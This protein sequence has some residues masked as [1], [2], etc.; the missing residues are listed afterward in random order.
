MGEGVGQP[1][2]RGDNK[3][4]E[5]RGQIFDKMGNTGGKIQ[6][7]NYAGQFC[8]MGFNSYE[9]FKISHDYETENKHNRQNFR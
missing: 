8:T 7:D 2:D 6:G 4:D 3:Q 1:I 5:S 9:L